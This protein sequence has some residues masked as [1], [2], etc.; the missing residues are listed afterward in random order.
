MDKDVTRIAEELKS[1]LL[2]LQPGRDAELLTAIIKHLEGST[3]IPKDI[4]EQYY[5]YLQ[6][7]YSVDKFGH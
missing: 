1:E 7:K 6:R 3:P 4:Q 2:T 5:V